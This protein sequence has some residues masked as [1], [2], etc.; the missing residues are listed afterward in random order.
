MVQLDNS[1]LL[2]SELNKRAPAK[3]RI[4]KKI[5]LKIRNEEKKKKKTKVK[6]TR[7]YT[8]RKKVFLNTYWHTY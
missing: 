2:R 6:I 4:G 3:A 5:D 1:H 7:K 8:R